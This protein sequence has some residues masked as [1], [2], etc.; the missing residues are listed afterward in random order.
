MKSAILD[1]VRR[2][3]VARGCDAAGMTMHGTMWLG[4]GHGVYELEELFEKM[5]RRREKIRR[6]SG[7]VGFE[8]ASR[9]EADV[10]VVI[11]AL[12][13]IIDGLAERSGAAATSARAGAM[14]VVAAGMLGAELV[15]RGFDPEGSAPHGTLVLRD[16]ETFRLSSLYRMLVSR[17][18]QADLEYSQVDAELGQ[19]IDDDLSRAIEALRGVV[20]ALAAS[21]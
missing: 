17:R 13:A 6:E 4:D 15:A 12:G 9:S 18:E 20:H 5:V 7:V 8:R 3:L 10:D 11:D 1:A 19:R 14:G 21:G 2:E 16:L